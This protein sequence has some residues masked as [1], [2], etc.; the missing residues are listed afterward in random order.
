ML[1]N[2]ETSSDKLM[3]IVLVGQP[4][5]E[6]YSTIGN[7]GSSNSELR[8]F[9]HYPLNTKES[10]AYIQHRLTKAGMNHTPVFTR[11]A[12]RKIVKRARGIPRVINILCDNALIAGSGIERNQ[13]TRRSS[14]VRLLIMTE[15]AFFS[16]MV[17]VVSGA[18]ALGAVCV[19]LLSP[20]SETCD[21]G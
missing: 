7:F 4:E 17:D 21:S 16:Q 19:F 12:L 6:K 2:L 3:Q 9:Y 1:S 14:I 5:F 11:V 18:A 15:K 8:P 13:S 10:L 20:Y